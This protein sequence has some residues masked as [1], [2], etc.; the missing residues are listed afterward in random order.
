M[1]RTCTVCSHRKLSEID[2]AL[3]SNESFRNIAK[4]FGV[5]ASAVYRHQQQH[6]SGA[7][8]QVNAVALT[9]QPET[10]MAK[11]IQLGDE[12]RRLGKKAEDA[13]DL[14]GALAAVRELVR[15]VELLGRIEGEISDPGEPT[16]INVVYVDMPGKAGR[17]AIPTASK[18]IIELP[19]SKAE[20][21]TEREANA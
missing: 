8:D 4:R 18:E 17:P 19:P 10:L 12:A 6:I 3:V 20:T 15:I 7:P 21:F 11:I 1:P 13:G 5:S 2:A 9:P 14:R 16:T